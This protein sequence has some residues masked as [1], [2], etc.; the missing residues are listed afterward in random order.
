MELSATALPLTKKKEWL[1]RL[2]ATAV[3]WYN[4]RSGGEQ[5]SPC[6]QCGI[7]RIWPLAR[8]ISVPSRRDWPRVQTSD[9]R[10]G[11]DT[12][13]NPQ[14]SCHNG[15]SF[16]SCCIF[17]N[18]FNMISSWEPLFRWGVL[19]FC[20]ETIV[21]QPLRGSQLS[22]NFAIPEYQQGGKI[23][24]LATSPSSCLFKQ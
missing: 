19:G 23:W 5:S 4:A 1:D 14:N 21:L 2:F 9:Y 20:G 3:S 6:P 24:N 10:H 22:F 13:D 7:G 11:I 16:E 12:S 15:K 8:P 18:Q 17:S